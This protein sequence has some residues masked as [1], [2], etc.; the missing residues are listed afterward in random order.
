MV[1]NSNWSEFYKDSMV[2]ILAACSFDHKPILLHL[3]KGHHKIF[4]HRKNFK[5]ENNWAFKEVYGKVIEVGR[6]CCK[7]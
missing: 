4:A 6:K 5:Y 3:S 1:A 7:T 2:E